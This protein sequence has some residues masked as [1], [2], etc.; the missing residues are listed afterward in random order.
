[1]RRFKML[2]GGFAGAILEINLSLGE[3]EKRHIAN[4][5]I[6]KFIGG[7]GLAI[8]MFYDEIDPCIAP[9]DE[10]N[11]LIISI[12]PLVG[13]GVPMACRA[14]LVTKSPLTGLLCCSNV[15]GFWA[16]F[17]KKAGY[18]MM[19]IK[20]KSKEP[21]YIWIDNDNV[22]IRDANH[23]WNKYD[24]WDTVDKLKRSL[25]SEVD[26]DDISVMAIGPA[27]E[28]LVTYASVIVDK[29]HA[30]GR[31]GCGA[32]LGQKK[33]KA[34]AVHGTKK[35]RVARPHKFSIVVKDVMK[36]I[37]NDPSYKTWSTYASLPVS[38][39]AFV[40]GCLPGKN[41]Q[42]TVIENWLETRTLEAVL[43]YITPKSQTK[44]RDIGCA[45]CPVQCFHQVEVRTGRFKGLKISSGTFVMPIIEF[46]AKCGINDLPA[47]WKCKELCH[48]YGLD[49]A[50]AAC[51]VAFAMELVQRKIIRENADRLKL[52]WGDEEAVFELLRKIAY[53]EGIGRLLA[54]G[55]SRAADEIGG[56]AR[57]L[58]ITVKKMELMG[59]DPRVGSV[60]WNLGTLINPRGGDNV[61]TTHFGIEMKSF[62]REV[63]D[64]VL[65]EW[66]DMP[67]EVKKEI[68]GKPPVIN[69]Y[70]FI[71]KALMVRWYSILTTIINSLGMCIFASV[72]LDALGP[73]HYAMLYSAV[74]G[75]DITVDELMKAGERIFNLHRMYNARMD[76]YRDADR[77]PSRFYEPIRDG[78]A[79]GTALNRG[80]I[81]NALDEIYNLMGW[82]KKYGI[83]V[84]QK[85]RELELEEEAKELKVYNKLKDL[86][87]YEKLLK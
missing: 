31:G 65:V 4:N 32:V 20:G 64:N 72:S 55:T 25:S 87:A 21:V 61:R 46:G 35:I 76:V 81:E 82:H 73:T 75:I 53:K 2:I 3:V 12:G 47:I 38:R 59:A 19:I 42:T 6:K 57:N 9:F 41:W 52:R 54:K 49:I 23:L 34:I 13:T 67:P 28:R 37:L 86:R 36:R 45:N 62:C 1:M 69:E 78:P 66:L 56:E 58:A 22:E 80:A 29:Y 5:L 85:I 51:A 44:I 10:R 63:K 15:G 18:D 11:I 74:T 24:T 17:F 50:S 8:K 14:D 33:V 43:P 79:K 27:G 60:A 39:G 83:P 30:A 16:T 48:R 84:Q 40:K 7:T 70:T 77:W 71:G 26:G 68:F